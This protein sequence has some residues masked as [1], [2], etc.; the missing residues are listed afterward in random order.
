MHYYYYYLPQCYRSFEQGSFVR[1]IFTAVTYHVS[2]LDFDTE[3][4]S[5]TLLNV[6][7]KISLMKFIQL[8]IVASKQGGF[9]TEKN[10]EWSLAPVIFLLRRVIINYIIIICVSINHGNSNEFLWKKPIY[11]FVCICLSVGS[12]SHTTRCA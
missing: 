11:D 5:S 3:S 6:M 10:I 2:E 4:S 8:N 12:Y 9:S 7:S 1:L